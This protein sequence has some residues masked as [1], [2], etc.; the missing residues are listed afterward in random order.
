MF[1]KHT[2]KEI[3]EISYISCLYRK[4][5]TKEYFFPHSA[6]LLFLSQK[7]QLNCFFS[8][9]SFFHT[10]C[11]LPLEQRMFPFCWDTSI[12]HTRNHLLHYS[13]YKAILPGLFPLPLRA[14]SAFPMTNGFHQTLHCVSLLYRKR[15]RYKRSSKV[16]GYYRALV[17][18]HDGTFG[19]TDS[20]C[21]FSH[22]DENNSTPKC[23]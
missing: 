13:G 12:W 20:Q 7:V 11:S 2:R 22:I 19:V 4:V 14:P 1:I 10:Q 21:L 17:R 16:T 9:N 23:S 3:K 5:T 18:R 8:L 15:T 6:H